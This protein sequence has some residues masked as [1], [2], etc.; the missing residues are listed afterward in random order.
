MKHFVSGKLFISSAAVK[1]VVLFGLRV[2]VNCLSGLPPD[3]RVRRSLVWAF[4]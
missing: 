3:R 4:F 1:G 2:E